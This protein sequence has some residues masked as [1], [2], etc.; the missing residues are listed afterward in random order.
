MVCL[1]EF[2]QLLP[3]QEPQPV[4]L[5]WW[6][7]TCV[8]PHSPVRLSALRRKEHKEDVEG[9]E[10]HLPSAGAGEVCHADFGSHPRPL[11]VAVA[12]VVT[13]MVVVSPPQG[14]GTGWRGSGSHNLRA[15]PRVPRGCTRSGAAAR[16]LLLPPFQH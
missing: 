11:A 8:G 14:H 10:E 13:G 3:L 5:I 15:Q 7:W 16:G 2:Q 6:G 4:S 9:S 1:L 12:V